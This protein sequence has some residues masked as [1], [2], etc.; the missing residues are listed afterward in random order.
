[1]MNFK[2]VLTM[3]ILILVL[4]VQ[5]SAGETEWI[6]HGKK[7]L[8]WGEATN[9]SGYMIKAV[10]FTPSRYFDVDHD[11]VLLGI[12]KDGINLD[13]AK[14]SFNNSLINDTAIL[15]K[16]KVKIVV[17][18][19]KTGYDVPSPH[20]V[21]QVYIL[22]EETILSISPEQWIDSTLE[23]SKLVLKDIYIG[24]WINVEIRVKNLKDID[25]D[26]M[27]NDSIPSG[28]E[29]VPNPDKKLIWNLGLAGKE[30]TD[31][32]QY[33]M[34]AAKPGTFTMPGA[35]VV[36][37]YHGATYIT[38]TDTSEIVV[39]G[40]DINLTKT[41][42]MLENKNIAVTVSVQNI[43]DRATF[44]RITD[45]IPENAEL[46]YGDLNFDVVA[47]PDKTYS[48]DYIIKT[49]NDN[50]PP[51][52]ATYKDNKERIHDV[53]SE[54]VTLAVQTSPSPTPLPTVISNTTQNVEAMQSSNN[55]SIREKLASIFQHIRLLLKM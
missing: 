32:C 25:L 49:S 51:V 46:V 50:L 8:Y 23:F 31:A 37:E 3:T 5:P 52:A 24:D 9:I 22:K 28:F 38:T 30:S 19:I 18:D 54:I 39:H 40:P 26:I 43:G 33:S 27:I 14:L 4:L 1:M 48:N 17:K 35:S 34:R 2:K 55:N 12:Y 53:R 41:A 42:K 29:V 7:T 47:Q 11:W 21:I 13:A 10:D 6:D 20:V 15:C 44:V 16:D 45:E 36:V